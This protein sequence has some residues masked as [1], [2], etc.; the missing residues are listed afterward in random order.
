VKISSE[1]ETWP[2]STTNYNAHNDHRKIDC[3]YLQRTNTW[4][5][6]KIN[7]LAPEFYI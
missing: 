3:G 6:W 5:F 2:T 4:T 1:V 7:P